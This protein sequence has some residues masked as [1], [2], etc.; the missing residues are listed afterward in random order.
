[1][2]LCLMAMTSAHPVSQGAMEVAITPERVSIR[3]TTSNEE[4]LVATAFSGRQ[5]ASHLDAVRAHGEYLLTHLRVFADER[6]LVGRLA[7]EPRADS[8]RPTFELEYPLTGAAPAQIRIEENVLREFE[9]APGNPWEAS[10]IVTV[11]QQGQSAVENQL[12]SFHQPLRITCWWKSGPNPTPRS[13]TWTTSVAFVHHGILHILTGYD[14]LLFVGALLFAITSFWDLAK[15]ISAFTVAHTLTL[16]LATLDLFRLPERVVEPMIAASIV[17]VSVQNIFFPGQSRGRSRLMVAFLFGL[18]H[19]LGFAGG[20]VE[21]IS[22]LSG[23]GVVAAIA[24]FSIG[25]EIGHQVVVLPAFMALR[26][27]RRFSVAAVYHHR[28]IQCWG[29]AVI[30]IAGMFYLIAALS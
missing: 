2:Y 14:H 4:V 3:V 15:V 1:M 24:A 11:R 12:L 20:L 25:V 29:S 23:H 17:V 26:S 28:T 19:G 21:A 30:S 8:T 16:I 22:T 9:F 13:S 10:Y 5:Y 18:F 7:S 6:L 27:V